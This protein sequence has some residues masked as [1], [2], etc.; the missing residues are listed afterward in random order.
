MVFQFKGATMRQP[1]WVVWITGLPGSGKSVIARA[2]HR[3]LTDMNID[4]EIL[5][6]DALRQILTPKPSYSEKERD[7]VYTTLAYIAELL[8]RNGA[9]VI[10]DSTGNLRK[11]RNLC[12]KHVDRFAEIYLDCPIQVCVQREKTRRRRF[13]APSQIYD[14]A[15]KGKSKTVPGMGARYEKPLS[16]EVTLNTNIVP[17]NE[18][19]GIIIA[20]LSDFLL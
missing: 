7:I 13:L 8:S 17:P 3:R 1:G 19:A 9:N 12:R 20:K 14:K 16:P 10:I 11:Y 18:S 4:S 15:Y 5:S 2:L 6:S